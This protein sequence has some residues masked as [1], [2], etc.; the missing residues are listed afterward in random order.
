MIKSKLPGTKP[1]IFAVM[2]ALSNK[3]NAVNLSQG[4]PDFDLDKE[5][6]DLFNFHLSAGHNQYAPM[7]GVPKLRQEISKKIKNLYGFWYDPELEINI[8]AG[9]TQAL[10]TVFNT[11]INPGDEVILFEPAYDSYIPAIQINGG[12]PVTIPLKLPDYSFDFD[13]VER[14]ISDKTKAIV[15]NS[16]HNPCGSVLSSENLKDLERI[17]EK[18]NLIVISDEVY[19]HIVFDNLHHISLCMS[20][21]LAKRSFVISSFGKTFHAT[22]WKVGYVAAPK[23]LMEEFRKV[24]QFTVFAVN[25]PAQF[26]YADYLSNPE[27]YLSLNEFYQNKRDFLLKGLSNTGLIPYKAQGTYFQLFDYSNISDINDSEFSEKMTIKGGVAVIPLSPFY[28]QNYNGKVIRICF[29][30]KNEVL[31]EGISRINKFLE[32]F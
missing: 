17:A 25:T 2:S 14:K 21:L 8:T 11:V 30:K 5:L 28:G 20:E 7:T 22:G 31:E 15:I 26:S 18:Y 13:E 19:E 27:K 3:H 12:I 16:P 4:F 24:H 1:S 10:Y 29:A 32:S 23:Y 9:A 6:I